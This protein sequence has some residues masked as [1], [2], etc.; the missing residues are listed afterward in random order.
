[1]RRAAREGSPSIVDRVRLRTGD[2]QSGADL[3]RGENP[4]QASRRP[5]RKTMRHWITSFSVVD[6][7]ANVGGNSHEWKGKSLAPL[8]LSATSPARHHRGGT[9]RPGAFSAGKDLLAES[10]LNQEH[11]G[12]S[13]DRARPRKGFRDA[14]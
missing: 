7:G 1:M 10:T 11:V 12:R 5:R 14:P 3:V 4:G 13:D 9:A 2:A 8:V 6:D